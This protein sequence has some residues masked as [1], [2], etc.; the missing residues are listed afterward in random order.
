MGRLGPGGFLVIAPI[1]NLVLAAG[2]G[3]AAECIDLCESNKCL[4]NAA[5]L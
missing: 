4:L 1:L 2:G 5:A 3:A